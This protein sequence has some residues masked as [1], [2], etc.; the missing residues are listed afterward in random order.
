MGLSIYVQKPEF[1]NNRDLETVGDDFINIDE[2]KELS[3]FD[4]FSFDYIVQYHDVKSGIENLG[5]IEE[6]LLYTGCEYNKDGSIFKY[7]DTKHILY[8]TYIFIDEIWSKT[9]FDTE[10]QLFESEYF[11]EFK[12]KYLSVLL[13]YGWEENYYFFAS[14]SG[15]YYYNLVDVW[16]YVRDQIKVHIINPPLIDKVEK[17]ITFS[18][19]GYQ[20]KGQNEEFRNEE[21]WLVTDTKTLYEH[22]EK[23]FSYDEEHKQN[24]KTNIID[25]FIEGETFVEY[26]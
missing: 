7:N 20:R 5:Y 2:N 23:Y 12:D 25:K 1:L 3:I 15:K 19:V 10:K 22:W 17:V 14:G 11:I 9:Y 6:N 18:E 4:K 24:F 13:N 8:D 21:K 16:N 26:C